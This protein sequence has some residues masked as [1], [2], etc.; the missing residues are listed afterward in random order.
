M[1]KTFLYLFERLSPTLQ[2]R[3]VYGAWDASKS[4]LVGI[5]LSIFQLTAPLSIRKPFMEMLQTLSDGKRALDES[6]I[7]AG[8][9]PRSDDFA[10]TWEDINRLQAVNTDETFICS[11]EYQ[12]VVKNIG[13]SALI[14]LI[15]QLLRLPVNK[16]MREKYTCVDRTPCKPYVE[17]LRED[18]KS[19]APV[20][21]PVPVPV[22][23]PA[24]V[25]APPTPVPTVPI[26]PTP[27]PA[28]A[29]VPA[30]PTPVPPVPPV[31][32]VPTP[33]PAP[34]PPASLTPT[35][36][37]G[38]LSRGGRRL[39]FTYKKHLHRQVRE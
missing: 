5:L 28:P 29:P 1:M 30:P 26:V 22:P 24:P 35:P 21:V 20:P 37:P 36:E 18:Q 38:A 23:A 32:T 10:P 12:E 17:A 4:L 19:P 16:E 39:R 31:P 6:L 14:R 11:C 7:Q 9:E 3:M 25:P 27:T 13:D 2:D 33:V 34:P 15:L 8:L